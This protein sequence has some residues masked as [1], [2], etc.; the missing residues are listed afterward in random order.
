MNECCET[1]RFKLDGERW[2]YGRGCKHEKLDGFIC[3]GLEY[4]GIAIQMVGNDPAT[5]TCE[6]YLPRR[7]EANETETE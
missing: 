6:N 5:G 2:T 3:L 7:T 1:C 4:E